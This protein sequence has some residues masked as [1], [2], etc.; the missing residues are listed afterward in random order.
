M[1]PNYIYNLY[2][3]KVLIQCWTLNEWSFNN[4]KWGD[5]KVIKSELNFKF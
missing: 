5:G 3:N 1:T 4:L 2:F